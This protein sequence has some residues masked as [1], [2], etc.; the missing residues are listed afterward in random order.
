MAN[1]IETVDMLLSQFKSYQPLSSE[2]QK[3]LDKKI[4]LEFNFNS[5]HIEGNTLTYGETEL[6][7]IFDDTKGNHTIREYDEM[8]SHDTAFELIKQWASEKERPLTEQNIKNLNEILLVRPFWKEAITPDG[9]STRRLIKIGNY[10]EHPNSVRLQNGEI[11]NYASPVDTPMLMKELMDWYRDEENKL[12][13]LTLATMLHYKFVRIHPFDDG[14]GRVA[15]LLMNYVFLRHGYPPVIIKS[16][17]KG[18]YLRV[19]RLAD[20]EDYEPLIFYVAEQLAWILQL[21]IKAGKGESI[22]E[23]GDFDKKLKE[24]K[25]KLN[26]NDSAKLRITKS[27]GAINNAYSLSIFPLIE[28]LANKLSEL[29]SFF[30]SS[31][32]SLRL[33][34]SSNHYNMSKDPLTF[35]DE[36]NRV[37]GT[38]V[39]LQNTYSFSHL[40]KS[41]KEFSVQVHLT[42]TFH[43][44]IFE[45]NSPL[46]K[47]QMDKLYDEKFTETEI[48]AV[49]EE[50]GNS[51]IDQVNNAL[52]NPQ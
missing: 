22:D 37:Q 8:R 10:K 36:T 2:T 5:N 51:L 49:V 46:T 9:Q 16:S 3:T 44:N 4:R 21:C 47:S 35:Q 23:P 28:K 40:R 14:N 39:S 12:H 18:N 48:D 27:V 33:S 15:R 30:K 32:E 13:P 20:V 1:Y 19:L 17:D 29:N 43:Q 24:L 41:K 25:R 6:L 42:F 34:T 38:I 52:D 50:I 26:T 31:Q 45:L 11:F 7:L